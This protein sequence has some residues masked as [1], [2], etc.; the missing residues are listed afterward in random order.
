MAPGAELQADRGHD[1]PLE[2]ITLGEHGFTSTMTS[3]EGP[4]EKPPATPRT[5]NLLEVEPEAAPKQQ[6]EE[7]E[8]RVE[9]EKK[10][11]K[12]AGKKSKGT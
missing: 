1:N 3:D 9:E 12:K 6:V 11:K 10:T 4:A 2:E 5:F 7:S 8:G